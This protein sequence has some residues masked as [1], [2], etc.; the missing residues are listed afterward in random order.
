MKIRLAA[1]GV[2]AL[3]VSLEGAA[4]AQPGSSSEPI[5]IGASLPLSAAPAWRRAQ[6]DPL[7][8]RG[9]RHSAIRLKYIEN[10]PVDSV[11]S[12][13][14]KVNP[15]QITQNIRSGKS[16]CS[17]SIDLEIKSFEC[18]KNQRYSQIYELSNCL[19]CFGSVDCWSEAKQGVRN[20]D[21]RSDRRYE[22]GKHGGLYRRINDQVRVRLG[23]LHSADIVMRS[24]DFAAIVGLQ[25]AEAWDEVGSVLSRIGCDLRNA[26]ANCLLICTNIMHKFT[27]SV[28]LGCTE[29]G[30][31]IGPQHLDLPTI[32]STLLHAAAAV[33]F[34]RDPT[35]PKWVRAA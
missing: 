19:T 5:V 35:S 8:D 11:H 27:D 28:I 31:L 4:Q 6:A 29:I 32:D 10:F 34:A 3:T 1:I 24:V 14:P 13:I 9:Y 26:G 7:R 12:V 30:L 2:L 21:D 15:G 20:A 22:L 17:I 18:W 25:Q 16:H 33:E 23:G